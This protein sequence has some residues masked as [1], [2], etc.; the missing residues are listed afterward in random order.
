M[1][2]I[3]SCGSVHCFSFHCH[4]NMLCSIFN[5]PL[6]CSQ[7]TWL[8]L[9]CSGRSN[10]ARQQHAASYERHIVSSCLIYNDIFIKF[11]KYYTISHSN[12]TGSK[13]DA[14]FWTYSQLKNTMQVSIMCDKSLNVSGE[15][16]EY[17]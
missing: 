7:R 16:F 6:Q 17:S 15:F 14:A 4:K 10:D 13:H 9:E 11:R 2:I 3:E 8:P 12:S 5:T 1:I